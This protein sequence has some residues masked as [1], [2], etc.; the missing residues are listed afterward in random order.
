M[1]DL[2]GFVVPVGSVCFKVNHMSDVSINKS[3]GKQEGSAVKMPSILNEA[4]GAVMRGSSSSHSAAAV[5]IGCIARA[6]G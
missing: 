2:K 4:I 6:L 5:R 1:N 3:I